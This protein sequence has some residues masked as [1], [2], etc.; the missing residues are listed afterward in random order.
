MQDADQVADGLEELAALLSFAGE[1]R[2]KVKAYEHAA[3]L[4]RA[5]GAVLG[6][7]VERQGL[8]ELSG[9][10]PALSRQIEELWNAG[11]SDYLS[12]LRS[13]HPEGAAELMGVEG[14]TP[15]RI[16]ALHA[17]LG[18][19]S[20]DE[21][22]AACV[23]GRVQTVRGFG[24]KTE[25]RLLAACERWQ[26]RDDGTP[27][28]LLMP[29]AL[30]L[31]ASF[32]RRLSKVASDV[33]LAGALRRGEELVGEIEFVVGG[34]VQ[35]ALR[36]VAGL[37]QVLRSDERALTAELADGG[38]LKLH[39]RGDSPGAALLIATGNAAHVDA[40]CRLAATRGIALA[41][42]VSTGSDPPAPLLPQQFANEAALYALGSNAG[43]DGS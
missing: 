24:K 34:D 17:A 10:G 9:I 26:S 1:A 15:R 3:R 12:R 8:R 32:E 25:E 16:R 23:T 39:P 40:V 42:T 27:R 29:H 11:T 19:R 38:T 30:E 13:E 43:C 14:M 36:H 35:A 21:L 28:L 5:L 4:T 2:F 31:A 6:G 7:L 37:R 22:L 20:V 41:Q 18:V 33:Q